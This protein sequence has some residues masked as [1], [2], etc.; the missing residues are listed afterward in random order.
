[1]SKEPSL[2]KEALDK[3]IELSR[4]IEEVFSS[5]GDQGISYFNIKQ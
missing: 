4:K 1:M 2:S 3:V 5:K